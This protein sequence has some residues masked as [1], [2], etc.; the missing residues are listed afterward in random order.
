MP[1]TSIKKTKP[2]TKKNSNITP[3][4]LKNYVKYKIDLYNACV[5]TYI[6]NTEGFLKTLGKD[7]EFEML[8]AFIKS[9]E[10]DSLGTCYYNGS[11]IVIF[12]KDHLSTEMYNTLFHEN[13]HAT[14]QI[15]NHIG[16]V[17]S[18]ES[19]EAYAYLNGYINEKS[20]TTLKEY[21]D[22]DRESQFTLL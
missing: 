11:H 19:E 18:K 16:M 5:F 14:M 8:F 7:K 21:L 12:I 9:K 13:L 22:E 6:G 17:Y 3:K 2:S 15:L 10:I 4:K 1:R 20:V